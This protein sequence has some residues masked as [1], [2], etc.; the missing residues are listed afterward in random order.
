MLDKSGDGLIDYSELAEG[1]H[2][3]A[4]E[5]KAAAGAPAPFRPPPAPP[6]LLVPAPR[7]FG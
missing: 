1:L 4:E 6:S 2:A 5:H 3:L 7:A